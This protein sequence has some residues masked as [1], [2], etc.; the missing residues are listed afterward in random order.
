MNY[1]ALGATK[2]AADCATELTSLIECRAW[3]C[4]AASQSGGVDIRYKW[5]SAN[6]DIFIHCYSGGSYRVH[7][8]DK[9]F[10]IDISC[11]STTAQQIAQIADI[12][13]Y[14]EDRVTEQ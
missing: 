5:P 13:Q 3:C 4:A 10:G 1:L 6:I 12:F 11:T 9:F 14:I 8:D 2:Q 7:I